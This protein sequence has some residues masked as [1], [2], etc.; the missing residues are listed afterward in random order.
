MRDDRVGPV[1]QRR[2]YVRALRKLPLKS[3]DGRKRSEH[4]STKRL[5]WGQAPERGAHVIRFDA[6]GRDA[7]PSAPNWA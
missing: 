3:R 2:M 4:R 1:Y 7:Q 6:K 5:G